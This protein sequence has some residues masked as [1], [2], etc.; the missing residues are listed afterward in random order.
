MLL[1]AGGAEPGLAESSEI[2]LSVHPGCLI[3]SEFHL[4]LELL[5]MERVA[6]VARSVGRD[7]PVL[8]PPI[9]RYKDYFRLDWSLTTV[10]RHLSY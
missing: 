3:Y 6:E 7:V 9:S 1:A 4:R 8:D 5:G 10:R 2:I